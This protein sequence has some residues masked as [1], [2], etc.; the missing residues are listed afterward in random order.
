MFEITLAERIATIVRARASGNFGEFRALEFGRCEVTAGDVR[1]LV[2]MSRLGL[3]CVAIVGKPGHFVGADTDL[4]TAVQ[5]A[6]E[7]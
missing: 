1:A 7:A 3:W 6:L 2:T 5:L 4:E